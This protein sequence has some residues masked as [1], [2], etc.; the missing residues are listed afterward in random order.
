MEEGE[1]GRKG[2]VGEKGETQG[3][4]GGEEEEGRGKVISPQFILIT[5]SI[6]N[7]RVP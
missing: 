4:K 3:E 7:G 6:Y 1:K 5:V 2:A